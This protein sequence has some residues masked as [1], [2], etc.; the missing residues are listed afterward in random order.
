[1]HGCLLLLLRLLLRL[2]LAYALRQ[3]AFARVE[4]KTLL[5]IFRSTLAVQRVIV[6]T[7]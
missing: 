5:R 1:M 4:R 3:T 6:G 7:K 2:L